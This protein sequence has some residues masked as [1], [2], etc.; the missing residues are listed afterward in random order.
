MASPQILAR[1]QAL[2]EGAELWKIASFVESFWTRRLNWLC[3]QILLKAPAQLHRLDSLQISE[4][5][6]RG[7]FMNPQPEPSFSEGAL[8]FASE[9]FLPNRWLHQSPIQTPETWITQGIQSAQ[10]LNA[11]G[12][13]FFLPDGMSSADFQMHWKLLPK[14]LQNLNLEVTFVGE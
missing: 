12:L 1:A 2:S 14:D 10:K 7:I 3:N 5:R 13:R 4:L 6:E 9:S 8:L 11:Q